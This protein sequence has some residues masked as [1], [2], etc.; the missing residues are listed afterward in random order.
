MK[1]DIKIENENDIVFYNDEEGN[2]QVEVLL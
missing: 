1:N 2:T